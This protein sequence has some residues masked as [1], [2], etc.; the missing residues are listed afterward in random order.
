V[1]RPGLQICACWL[2]IAA[3]AAAL[4][5][6]R[7]PRPDTP[8]PTAATRQIVDAAGRTVTL[9]LQINR[10]ADPWPANNATVLMLGGADKLVATSL[11]ARNQPWLRK[12]YPRID[13]VPAAFDAGGEV[14]V[15]TLIGAQPDV[16]L[17]AYGGTLPRWMDAIAAYHIPVV[18]LPND[19]LDA[20]RTTVRMTGA[21][22]G[23]RESRVATEYIRY[24]D[25]NIRRVSEVTS[26]LPNIGRPTVL[27]TASAGILTIDGRRSVIDDW[28]SVAGGINAADVV[29]LGRPV[30]MEQ[31]AAWNPDVIIVGTAPNRQNR[32]A[33][34]SDP[35]WAQI[36]AVTHGRVVVNPSGAYLWDRHSAEAAL[37]ILWAAKLLHPALFAD[38]D[39]GAET[40]SFYARFFHYALTDSELSSIM[41]A[42]PP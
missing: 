34:L 38:L 36:K 9:P 1:A 33:I 20:L 35:R 15:E 29:G 37:Q 16:I 3:T 26:R 22:L 13:Q 30:T 42:A 19:S 6:S 5:Q 41:A 7:A 24:F 8:P 39:V 32:Q 28:I 17:M 2:G 12:L 40:K 14:N 21:V 31:V 27:H 23:A 10:I 11:Q 4:A 18:M 25:A